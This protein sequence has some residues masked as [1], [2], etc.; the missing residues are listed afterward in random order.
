MTETTKNTTSRRA[1]T[2]GL[3]WSV[4]AVAAASA[5]PAMA[6]TTPAEPL[7]D[8][9][10]AVGGEALESNANC[11]YTNLQL[12]T[13]D[14]FSGANDG[15]GIYEMAGAESP[16]TMATVDGPLDLVFALPVGLFGKYVDPRTAFRIVEG[17]YAPP[18]V[19]DTVTMTNPI[20]GVTEDYYV[21]VYRYQGS[22]T[23]STAVPGSG[24]TFDGSILRLDTNDGKLNSS[25]CGNPDGTL[26]V[27]TGF[28][29]GGYQGDW[30]QTGSFTTETG[31]TGQIDFPIDSNYPDN[32]ES[33]I[34]LGQR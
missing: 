10:L 6:A 15:F 27:R 14:P 3:A 19:V 20:T 2:Q 12:G 32:P 21:F 33:W 9:Q 28:F 13:L 34:T 22:L 1:V 18:E 30:T 24:N 8:Y 25:Y 7:Y 29:A 11:G 26:D 16:A 4:P 23:Q 17:N 31:Y 5:A